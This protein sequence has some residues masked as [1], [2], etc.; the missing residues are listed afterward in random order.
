M[1]PSLP[2]MH[3]F[4]CLANVLSPF[5][6]LLKRHPGCEASSSPQLPVPAQ[7]SSSSILGA[8]T[9]HGPVTTT[10]SLPITGPLRHQQHPPHLFF[11]PRFLFNTCHYKFLN[12]I[13]LFFCLLHYTI[14]F[15]R[16]GLGLAHLPYLHTGHL[17]DM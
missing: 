11:Q 8:R 4:A 1:G 9:P 10:N 17:S 16:A 3:D 7:D 5:T 13:C 15:P 12:H 2:G 6:L 14:S